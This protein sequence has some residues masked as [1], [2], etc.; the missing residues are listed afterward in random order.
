MRERSARA[1][2]R[3]RGEENAK[4]RDRKKRPA[5]AAQDRILWRSIKS[6][7][8]QSFL[9]DDPGNGRAVALLI[10]LPAANFSPSLL[11]FF[12]RFLILS[13]RVG[14]LSLPPIAT[15]SR[16]LYI[17]AL[18]TARVA[19]PTF[20]IRVPCIM[21]YA[22]VILFPSLFVRPDTRKTRFQGLNLYQNLPSQTDNEI[23]LTNGQSNGILRRDKASKCL[24]TN[25]VKI[26]VRLV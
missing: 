4:G 23:S 26:N 6:W 16:V 10:P 7:Q 25:I 1:G 17:V 19:P 14:P 8:V 12:L 3:Q 11:L 24:R 13:R 18:H 9:R 20:L 21:P 5:A 15:P 2:E 22:T